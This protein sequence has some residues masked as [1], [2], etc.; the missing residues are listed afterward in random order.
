MLVDQEVVVGERVIDLVLSSIQ[1]D[2]VVE[3]VERAD[4]GGTSLTLRN[5]LSPKLFYPH[6]AFQFAKPSEHQFSLWLA[7]P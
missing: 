5:C 2:I 1:V 3:V 4:D 6:F 7:V